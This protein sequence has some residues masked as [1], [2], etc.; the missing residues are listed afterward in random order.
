[1]QSL[2][3][4]LNL[5]NAS[6]TLRGKLIQIELFVRVQHALKSGYK[7]RKLKNNNVLSSEKMSREK[8]I[9]T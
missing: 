3:Y 7:Q 9:S 8:Y 4:I 5:Y 1:M 6:L 2:Y